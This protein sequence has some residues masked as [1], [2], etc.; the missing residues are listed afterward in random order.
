MT[1]RI[2][3]C[4]R[5]FVHKNFSESRVLGKAISA[6]PGGLFAEREREKDKDLV[7]ANKPCVY[8]VL[9]FKPGCL[10]GGAYM[11]AA[12]QISRLCY[13]YD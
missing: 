5:V 12:A 13:L 1:T 3:C 2:M 11:A 7:I 6:S 4:G 10:C 8:V 9:S